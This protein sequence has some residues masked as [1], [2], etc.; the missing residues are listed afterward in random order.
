MYILLTGR[1]PYSGR[2]TETIL[3]QVKNT[4]FV[5]NPLKLN[6]LSD[7]AVQLLIELLAFSPN[8]RISARDAIQS[9]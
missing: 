7:E 1:P 8:K 6:G 5:V 9:P 4:P 3:K 2:D